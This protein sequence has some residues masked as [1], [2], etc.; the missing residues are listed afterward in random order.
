MRPIT[1]VES[2][3]FLAILKTP[4]IPEGK[5]Y[6]VQNVID[7]LRILDLEPRS[8]GDIPTCIRISG[9]TMEGFIAVLGSTA[10]AAAFVA[11]NATTLGGAGLAIVRVALG[12]GMFK[13]GL[14]RCPIDEKRLT[15][16]PM[17][18]SSLELMS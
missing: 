13:T 7:Q 1:I 9:L 11:L 14:D 6:T 10:I 12:C 2:Q 16:S 3:K 17:R 18:G 4:M 8:L 5:L 15:H